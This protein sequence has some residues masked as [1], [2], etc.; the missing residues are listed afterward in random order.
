MHQAH[1]PR[2]PMGVVMSWMMERL[3]GP[4]NR[5]T[6]E[7]LQPPPGGAVLEIGFGPGHALEMLASTRRLSLVAGVD[8]SE[9]MVETARRRLARKRGDA[10]LDLRLGD[11]RALPFDDEQF[12]LVY[13]VNSF[14][15]WPAKEDALAEVAGVLK[16]GGDV[17]LSI[18]DFRVGGRFEPPG[19]GAATAKAAADGLRN[20]G[21]QVRTREIPHSKQRATFLVRGRK[22]GRG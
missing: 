7:A 4:Q 20:L 18:R 2:G 19:K 16:P 14:H 5:A 6:V 12:D 9:L 22:A 21:L 3:N 1:L 10:A 8:H 11:A 17:V 13:A 15:L